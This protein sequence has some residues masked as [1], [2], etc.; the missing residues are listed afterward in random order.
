MNAP[1]PDAGPAVASSGQAVLQTLEIPGPAGR[2]EALL[3]AGDADA[4]YSVLVCHP[5][6]PSGG[7]MHTKVVYQAMKAF[8]G[9]GLPV[10]RFN[11]RGTGR[12]Q[13]VH[14][15]G[16]GEVDDVR[17]ALAWLDG[18]FRV[19]VIFA[20]FSF[21][22]NVGLRACC[23]DARVRGIVALGVPMH[24][25]GRD[26]TYN[27]L[28]G[29][30]QPKLFISGTRDEFASVASVEKLVS[31]APHAKLI[32]VPEADHF[33]TGKLDQVRDGIREWT[34]AN[35]LPPISEGSPLVR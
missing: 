28:P 27:F 34:Q 35:F 13:G 18:E 24:A 25:A 30:A 20:G 15:F 19:P 6:P 23:G 5:H 11:F 29:C 16:R 22:S 10:L 33:F 32:W 17:A 2:L 14:D 7:T 1:S 4:P 9:L 31:S 26:Y 12:S 8:N 3:N 21:G